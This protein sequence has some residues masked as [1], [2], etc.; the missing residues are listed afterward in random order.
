MRIGEVR[1]LGTEELKKQLEGAHEELFNV[2]LRLAT[3]Q[4]TNHREIV[5]LGKKISRIETVLR[6]R[7]LGIRQA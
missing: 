4:L 7:E 6:E 5:R 3:K 2:R 1:A